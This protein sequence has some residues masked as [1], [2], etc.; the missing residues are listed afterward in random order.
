MTEENEPLCIRKVG[1]QWGTV[2]LP[3][4]LKDRKRV[5]FEKELSTGR[6]YVRG[7]KNVSGLDESGEGE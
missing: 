3:D 6:I 7:I 1:K 4:E 2:T 5:V